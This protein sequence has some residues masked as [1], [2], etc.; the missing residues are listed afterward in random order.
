MNALRLAAALLLLPSAAAQVPAFSASFD[1]DPVGQAP[2]AVPGL[3]GARP[4]GLFGQAAARIRVVPVFGA[5]G[6]SGASGNV[7]R[8]DAPAA[9]DF[10]LLDFDATLV[11]G[12]VTSGTVR[13]GL[14]VLLDPVRASEGFAFLRVTDEGGEDVGSV[15]LAF[16][17]ASVSLGLLDYDPATGDFRGVV[18]PDN[19]SY[20]AGTWHRIDL[21]LDLDANTLRLAVDGTD[22]GIQTGLNRASGAGVAGMFLNW[23][24]AY[25]GASA[26]DNV[27]LTVPD[28]QA[29]PAAPP[30][31]AALL[32][33]TTPGTVLRVPDGDLRARGVAFDNDTSVPLVWAPVYDGVATYRIVVAN[34]DIDEADARPRFVRRVPILP[35]RTYEVSALIRTDFPR[36]TWEVS[37][38]LEGTEGPDGDVLFGGRYGGMPA[39]TERPGRLA[40]LDVAL[41]AALADRDAR[42][43]RAGRPRVR[44]GLRR[45]R[46]VR[47]RRSGPRRD[48]HRGARPICARRGRHVRRRAG[49]PRHA[50]RRRDRDR[51]RTDRAD[52]GRHVRLRPPGGH[53]HAAAAPDGRARAG[54]RDRNGPVGPDGP[55]SSLPTSSCS[56]ATRS[57]SAC[58]PTARS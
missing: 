31:F 29:L 30:G 18:Y 9:G 56:S 28:A 16:D 22:R 48:P 21:T 15:I 32:T 8:L 40:A 45:R 19:S 4:T 43:R 51:Q 58:R 47:D 42:Q 50:N 36:A 6:A 26:V 55:E 39:L 11:A 14:D 53:A 54:R 33:P 10:Q 49:R 1:D 13:A 7:A 25:A 27:T 37:A 38:Y 17:G 46:V 5:V 35:N 12:V 41:Y 20:A 3:G 2:L 24:Q 52:A 44:P 34:P 23:G 57:R